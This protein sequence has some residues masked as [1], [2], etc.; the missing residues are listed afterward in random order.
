[1]TLT[2]DEKIEKIT[3]NDEAMK[4]LVAL[5][6]ECG[7][8]ATTSEVRQE[9]GLDSSKVSYLADRLSDGGNRNVTP[10]EVL[11]I[12]RPQSMK[13]G[14]APPKE[15]WVA[16]EEVVREVLHEVE[17]EEHRMETLRELREENEELRDEIASL[18]DEM[19]ERFGNVK[20]ML[21]ELH[22]GDE[23][24]AASKGLKENRQGV[25]TSDD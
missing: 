14:Q 12:N 8:S 6:E 3:S 9:S 24:R 22:S 23:L 25:T 10:V 20:A 19:K 1:M 16:D 15:V 18:E 4:F 21:R 7:G 11:G 17:A 2:Q 5:A 13:N